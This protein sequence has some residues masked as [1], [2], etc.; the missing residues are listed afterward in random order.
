MSASLLF[1]FQK[2]TTYSSALM[3]PKSLC[4]PGVAGR[5]VYPNYRY[6]FP[7]KARACYKEKVELFT[8][9]G[10]R[11]RDREREREARLVQGIVFLAFLRL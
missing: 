11:E 6:C 3:K 7:I 8:N 5:L 1:A 2:E 4:F 10:K 9:S